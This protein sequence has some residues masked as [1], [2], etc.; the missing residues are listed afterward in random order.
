MNV[1]MLK[2]K[3]HKEKLNTLNIT[4]HIGHDHFKTFI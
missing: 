1:K 3:K 2:S 4:E